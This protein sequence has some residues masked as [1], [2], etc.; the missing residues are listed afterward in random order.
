MF[1][2]VVCWGAW[3]IWLSVIRGKFVHSQRFVLLTVNLPKQT[4]QSPKAVENVFSHLGGLYRGLTWKEL[5]WEGQLQTNFSFE[6]VSIGGYIRFYVRMNERYR[7]LLEATIFAQ[8]PD[9]EIIETTDYAKD[10]PSYFPNET[11]ELWGTEFILRKPDAYPLKT[12]PA[13]EHGPSKEYF[14]DPLASV[15]EFLSKLQKGEQLWLQILLQPTT[16]DWRKKGEAE[17]EKFMAK[18]KVKGKGTEEAPSLGMFTMTPGERRTIEAMQIKMGKTGFSTKIR[19]IYVGEKGVFRKG[20]IIG[21]MKGALL[22]YAELNEFKS[23]GLVSPK[24]DYFWQKNKIFEYL[25]F[26]FYKTWR[27]RQ[28][29]IIKNYIG[30]DIWAGGPM[31]ILNSEELATLYHFPMT[32]VKAPL[33]RKTESKKAEPPF[34]LPTE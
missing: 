34:S 14:K 33:V 22:Q 6:L 5:Y 12:Y 15:L 20:P 2:W 18:F 28:N 17:I 13:F 8:Y 10:V 1:V 25:S 9:A 11:H 30:R 4:E 24:T 32:E 3:H 7:D 19:F 31:Y 16:S 21:A 29:R 27:T 23:Y 26:G